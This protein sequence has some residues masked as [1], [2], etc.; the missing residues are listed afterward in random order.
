MHIYQ[1]KIISLDADNNIYH[2]LVEE[3]GRIIYLGDSLPPEY[4]K[5]GSVTELGNRVL[6]PSF[7]DGH[8]HYSNWI[9]FSVLY[10]DVREAKNIS[11]I[12]KIIQDFLEQSDKCKVVVAFGMSK[13]SVK[14]KRLITRAELDQVCPDLPMLMICYDGHSAVFNSKLL[15][16]NG[17]TK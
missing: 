6:L 3:Q 11:E 14:E 15:E 2:Y 1:G 10:F 9:L 16:K 8:L 7:G 5:N 17:S 12:Q 13:H 4:E